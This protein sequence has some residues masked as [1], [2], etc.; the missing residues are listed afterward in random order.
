MW[1]SAEG[2]GSS[3]RGFVLALAQGVRFE[4]DLAVGDGGFSGPF[5][6]THRRWSGA[7]SDG[8][9]D[10]ALEPVELQQSG[11]GRGEILAGKAGELDFAGAIARAARPRD[12]VRGRDGG[13]GTFRLGLGRF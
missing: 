2:N 12:D 7:L 11:D 4:L 3:E 13:L 8:D 1:R 5:I 10:A 6:E 9:G